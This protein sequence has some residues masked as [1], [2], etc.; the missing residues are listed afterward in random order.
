MKTGQPRSSSRNTKAL[1][2]HQYLCA[3]AVKETDAASEEASTA[4]CSERDAGSG[5]WSNVDFLHLW[6][7]D[8]AGM[9]EPPEVL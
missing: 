6:N 2:P 5:S 8:S 7:M 3:D 9:Q 1:V 4:D